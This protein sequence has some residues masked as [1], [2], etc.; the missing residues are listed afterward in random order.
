MAMNLIPSA[1]ATRA[2]STILLPT[3]PN[4]YST[5][6][7][8]KA[9]TSSEAPLTNSPSTSLCSVIVSACTK[10]WNCER[11]PLKEKI[12]SKR[13]KSHQNNRNG[14]NKINSPKQAEPTVIYPTLQFSIGQECNTWLV[15][16][17]YNTERQQNAISPT[18]GTLAKTLD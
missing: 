3:I 6:W 11:N 5:P 4:M 10:T 18:W 8:F 9:D 7:V 2:I 12:L 17:L 15:S 16:N 13:E 14:W 1:C